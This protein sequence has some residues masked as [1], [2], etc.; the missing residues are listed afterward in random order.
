MMTTDNLRNRVFIS[1][2]CLIKT[3]I[4]IPCCVFYDYK[5]YCAIYKPPRIIRRFLPPR[6]FDFL[7]DKVGGNVE[8]S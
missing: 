2:P 1:K 6:N 8:E 5:L 7:N 3:Y 4:K